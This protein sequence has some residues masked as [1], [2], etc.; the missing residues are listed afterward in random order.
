MTAPS[1]DNCQPWE[2]HWDGQILRIKHLEELGR[3]GLNMNHNASHIAFGCLAE[4]VK[5]AASHEG[6]QTKIHFS[7]AS[8]FWL[9]IE[10][11]PEGTPDGLFSFIEKRMCDRRLY[12][13]GDLPKECLQEIQQQTRGISG[14]HIYKQDHVSDKFMQALQKG[15]EYVWEHPPMMADLLSWMRMSEKEKHSTRD[16]LPWRNLGVDPIGALMLGYLK[17]HQSFITAMRTLGFYKQLHSLIKK[18]VRSSACLLCFAVEDASFRDISDRFFSIGRVSLRT[19]LVLTKYGFAAQPIT[20]TT[21]LPFQVYNK[22][23]NPDA[24]NAFLNFFEQTYALAKSEF[25]MPDEHSPVW[26]FRVGLSPQLPE[27]MQTLRRDFR[28]QLFI[29]N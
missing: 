27:K 26:G 23:K 28:T 14:V 4:I 20:A 7:I 3:H 5:I 9:S 24:K 13:K 25:R 22:I 12:K 11:A 18:Q 29:D 15:E 19:W 17:K 8:P 6:L 16:G 2:F 1:G 10:F 21:F